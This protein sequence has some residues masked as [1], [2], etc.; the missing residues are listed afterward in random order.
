MILLR[1]INKLHWYSYTGC[2]EGS[3]SNC[4][5]SHI[6]LLCSLQFNWFIDPGKICKYVAL[7][8]IGLYYVTCYLLPS[9]FLSLCHCFRLFKLVQ[10]SCLWQG[11]SCRQSAPS[12]LGK[13]WSCVLLY[14]NSNDGHRSIFSTAVISIL[15]F[16]GAFES[17]QSTSN[18]ESKLQWQVVT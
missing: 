2:E 11:F 4:H 15:F 17:T 5:W 12:C 1:P 10:S 13:C 8:H 6:W 9:N 14:V 3:K 7:F 16:S 18:T